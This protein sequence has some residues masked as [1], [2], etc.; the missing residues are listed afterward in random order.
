ML[1]KKKPLKPAETNDKSAPVIEKDVTIKPSAMPDVKKEL[2]SK[3]PALKPAETADKSAPAIDPNVAVKK[4]PMGD[5]LNEVKD[6]S[7][8]YRQ[9]ENAKEVL[10]D[11]AAPTKRPSL[12]TVKTV[13]KSAPVIESDVKLK[14]NPMAQLKKEIAGSKEL[15]PAET[16]DKSAPVVDKDV[17]LKESP[18]AALS[19]EIA[20][21]KDEITGFATTGATRVAAVDVMTEVKTKRPS[22][23]HVEATADK[24]APVIEKDV[25]IKANPM[26]EL[27]KEIAGSSP[28]LKPAETVDKSAPMI[29]KD[30]AV[31]PSPMPALAG[32]IKSRLSS[33]AIETD[34]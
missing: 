28:Q 19:K 4:S 20:E 2:T 17:K 34:A 13:D 3:S 14:M 15:K 11:V 23:S 32:E 10:A 16:V 1:G 6:K 26:A 30:V 25:A 29:E 8:E 31:K 9:A 27:K 22:L 24:S 12:S 5:L 21:K 33:S 7:A 18:M